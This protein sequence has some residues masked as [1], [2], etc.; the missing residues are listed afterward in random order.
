M[1]VLESIWWLLVLIGVMILVHE[2]GHYWA[3]RLFDVRVETFSFGFGPRLFGFRRGETDFRFSAILFGGYVK[4]SGEQPGEETAADPRS[5]AAK[6]RW[7]RLIIAFAGPGM[8]I[9]LAV[10]L[11]TGLFMLR[12][13]RLA[14]ADAPATIGYIEKGSAAA[15]AGLREGDV[16]VQV[17]DATNPKWEDVVL[18]EVASAKAPLEIGFRRDGERRHTTVVPVLDPKTGVGNAGW[19]QESRVQIAGIIAGMHAEE[20]GLKKGDVILKVNGETIRSLTKLHEIIRASNGKPVEIVYQRNGQQRQAAVTP[21]FS[22]ANGQSRWMIGVELELPVVI[23]KLSFPQALKEAVERNIKMAG[24]IYNFLGGLIEQR[25][26]PKSLEGPIGIARLSGQAAR[27]GPLAF[28]DLMSMVSL[29]LAIFNLLP[30]P[31]LDGGLIL[32][33]LVEMVMRRDLSLQVKE[34]VL[35]VGMMFLI[36]VV[37][38]VLYND[39]S[40]LLPG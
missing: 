36:A 10:A 28:V 30:I 1:A 24:L 31:I 27:E 19:E 2:L 22:E 29:N 21:T 14:N 5:F 35:K 6:P 4:M 3:A 39:I 37:V 9:I 40:K 15:E 26:S 13:P 12:F 20:A 33:L 23:T 18:Q 16:I 38:F 17:G 7:Q 34:A 8:N 25:M 11:L 32:M